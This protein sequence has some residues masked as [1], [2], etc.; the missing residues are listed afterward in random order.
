MAE[1]PESESQRAH[2]DASF[3]ILFFVRRGG[4]SGFGE[5]I[6]QFHLIPLLRHRHMLPFAPTPLGN[7][8]CD[9]SAIILQKVMQHYLTA[10]GRF[11]GER[12][13]SLRHYVFFTIC[14]K[15]W[16]SPELFFTKFFQK[17]GLQCSLTDSGRGIFF[18]FCGIPAEVSCQLFR[19]SLYIS[20]TA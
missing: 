12:Y 20:H 18:C 11:W 4:L 7:P 3:K 19:V 16:V 9:T 2:T 8:R 14:W 6:R 15:P 5:I 17:P 13:C 10:Q 1:I